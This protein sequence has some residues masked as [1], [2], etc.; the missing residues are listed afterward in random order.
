MKKEFI[1]KIF[2]WFLFVTTSV[3]FCQQE[4]KTRF[5]FENQWTV[6]QGEIVFEREKGFDY[7]IGCSKPAPVV[8]VS[9]NPVSSPVEFRGFVRLR[10]INNKSSYASFQIAKKEVSDPGLT[11][12]LS[13]TD[14]PLYPERV[15]CSVRYQGKYLHDNNEIGKNMD[16]IPA[17]S[18]D[19]VYLLKAYPRI[20]PGWEER[21]RRQIE[22]DMAE[23][24][25]HNSKWIEVRILLKENSVW[26]WVDDRL[27]VYKKDAGIPEQGYAGITFSSG[28]QISNVSISVPEDIPGNFYPVRLSGYANGRFINGKVYVKPFSN[29]DAITRISGIP[30]IL[31]SVNI[32]GNDHLDVSKSFYREGNLEGYFPVYQHAFAGSANRDPT[33][34]QL[35]IPFDYYDAL[36]MLAAA[37]GRP[38]S[39][40]VVTAMFYRPGAGYAE[41]FETRVPLF[42]STSGSIARFPVVLSNGKKV[43]LHLL[44]IPLDMGKLSSFS[45]LDIFEIELTKKVVQY[46]SYPDP[47]IYGWHQAGLPSSVHIYAVTL[48]KSPFIFSI[49]PEIFGSV[50]TSPEVPSYIIK[51]SSSKEKFSGKIHLQAI[52]YDKTDVINIEKNVA[53]EKPSVQEIKVPIPAKLYGWYQMFATLQT[54]DKTWTETRNFVVLAPDTRSEKWNG[55]GAL[56]GY[57]S[58]HGGHYTPKPEHHIRLMTM[59]GAR[60]S[61]GLP[62]GA[63]SNPY[64]KKHWSRVPAGAWEVSAQDWA[65]EQPYDK[66]KYEQYKKKVIEAYTK[67]RNAVP[68]QYRPDHV[69][70]FPEPGISN[71]MTA[72]NYPEYWGEPG[73]EPTE[74]E[75]KN[76]RM[77][78]V[79]AQCAA[80]AIRETWPE[81]KILIPW[82]DPLF[83]VPLLRAGFPKNLIDGSGLDICGF[84]RLPEQQL[85]QISVHRLYELK[86]EYEKAGIKNPDLRYCE[87]IFVPTEIGACSWQEQMDI[88]NR[89]ALISMA[90]G[91]KHFYSGWFAFD[92]GNYY[93]AEHYGGCGIFRRIPYCDPKPAYAAYATMTD[94]LNEAEFE[95]WIPTGSL[96]VYCLKFKGPKGNV[97]SLWTIRGKRPVTLTVSGNE[98]ITITDV[99]NNSVILTPVS[100]RIIITLS[101]SV[102][103]VTTNNELVSVDVGT[104]DHSDSMSSKNAKIVADT[105]DGKWKFTEQRDLIYENNN[106]DTFRY[107]GKFSSSIQKDPVFGNVLVSKLEKQDKVHQ[108]MPWYSILA[109]EKPIV[110]PGAPSHIG[111]WVK[112]ASDWGRVVFCLRDAKGER[113]ISIGT[114]DQWNCDDVHSWSYFNFDGWRYIRFELPGHEP[115][116]CF[117]KYTTTWYRSVEGDGIVDLPL[118]LENI[119]VEQ[120]THILYVNDVQ[121]VSSDTVCFGKIYVEFEKQED[122]T[123]KAVAVSKIRMPEPKEIPQLP[124]PIVEMEKNGIYPPTSIVKLQPPSWGA[125]G[126]N[127]HVYFKEVEQADKYFIWVG[128]Y[129]DGRGAVN[130]TPDGAKNGQHIYGLR[131]GI[132]LYWWIVWSDKQGNISKPSKAHCETLVDM[133]KEK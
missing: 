112:G 20:L 84:E 75:K 40:P 72:G 133:F 66:A 12:S 122:A 5:V 70:F 102:T 27:I 126:T 15:N 25:D 120:R 48:E 63:E 96:T 95:K 24:P 125:D 60:T 42:T 113:W 111:I 83:I 78:F 91:I 7:V 55:K 1:L 13:L 43:N 10:T 130:M 80:E 22:K 67:A 68:E 81:L 74:E 53:L 98:N 121:P 92:C 31:P 73:F 99:M 106:F 4:S 47:I 82:G 77:Y 85:H 101:T 18:N 11:I 127:V 79:T 9:K 6:K 108:L 86:K 34:I 51:I 119:I 3:V 57:W 39:I 118:K 23:L 94:K 44:K 58:Y 2:L 131:P 45:D 26:C 8:L 32:E 41:N 46:R 65:A 76:I 97:Y 104:P 110:L 69:Y 38:N 36:Y 132:K 61:I 56:F 115:Y 14:H 21:Y 103:Y 37:D 93:G 71:R 116:D 117:R 16:W 128:A 59:A 107:K 49:N 17:F 28:V 29:P 64:V 62:Q 90:Y 87:G 89:W 100:N 19:F 50:W 35:R 30:F 54:Q 129:P 105:G 123:E 52:S 114:K 88:Y 33:R 124:N 109:P